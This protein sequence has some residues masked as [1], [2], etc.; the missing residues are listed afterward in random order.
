LASLLRDRSA[1]LAF[2]QAV[3]DYQIAYVKLASRLQKL[4]GVRRLKESRVLDIGCGYTYPTVALLAAAGVEVCGIDLEPVFF[5]DG[6]LAR[7]RQRLCEAGL[8]RALDAAGPRY[9]QRQHY[10]AALTALSHVT[11]THGA[12]SLHTYDGHTLPFPDGS[13]DAVVSTAV[14]EHVSDIPV[15]VREVARVLRPGGVVDMLWH[16]FYSPSG[17]HRHASD[18]AVSPW[19]HVTGESRLSE[20]LNKKRPDEI[21]REFA[22]HLTVRRVIGASEDHTLEDEP[23]YAPEGEDWLTEAWRKAL[24]GLSDDLLTTRAYL[25]QAVREDV[26][27]GMWS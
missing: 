15:F 8:I 19:G 1:D 4:L 6:R 18:V 3:H 5:R 16:N 22:N 27:N 23:G 17:G 14:L 20:Y 26:P 13:F 11:I 21:E 10:F 24:P 7:F 12:L 9:T 2:E 25:I